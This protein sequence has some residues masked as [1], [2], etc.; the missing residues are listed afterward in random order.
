M[1]LVKILYMRGSNA[2]AREDL[3]DAASCEVNQSGL[4]EYVISSMRRNLK[5]GK[6]PIVVCR[7]NP[8]SKMLEYWLEIVPF[9]T[10]ATI[11]VYSQT[12]FVYETIVLR[13]PK[14]DTKYS[15]VKLSVD[16]G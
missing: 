12:I 11:D 3:S 7:E 2:I 13:Y 8:I 5:I 14:L 4:V 10:T 16:S 1:I 6:H 9:P 15:M